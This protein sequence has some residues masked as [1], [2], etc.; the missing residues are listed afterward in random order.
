MVSLGP[1]SAG[2]VQSMS[3]LLQ[4]M[5]DPE[6]ARAHVADLER[7]FNDIKAVDDQI[8]VRNE[9]FVNGTKQF[10][11]DRIE[12]Q[13]RVAVFEALAEKTKA[14]IR[15]QQDASDK[16]E[17]DLAARETALA[18]REQAHKEILEGFEAEQHIANDKM[19]ERTA[20]VEAREK[21]VA[22]KE[23]AVAKMIKDTSAALV[24][25]LHKQN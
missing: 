3:M 19:V 4:V 15:A 13:K 20:A 9:E 23:D 2:D 12:H 22:S 18:A 11:T 17:A 1:I 14:D 7:R 21:L 8:R 5:T 16:R 24:G 6:R 10:E 25:T